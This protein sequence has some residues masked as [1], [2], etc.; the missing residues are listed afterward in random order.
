V[1][2]SVYKQTMITGF[3]R[4]FK[5]VF[6]GWLIVM[7]MSLPIF[8]EPNDN[9]FDFEFDYKETAQLLSDYL[10]TDY[11]L[12]DLVE[13]CDCLVKIY[14]EDNQLVR[15]GKQNNEIILNLISRSDF[16][17]QENGIKYYR[18]NK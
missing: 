18:L 1:E 9:T 16:L 4:K 14:N 12:D 6:T 15:F 13:K 10:K 17:I 7:G 2:E 5:V 11:V 8:A 3:M